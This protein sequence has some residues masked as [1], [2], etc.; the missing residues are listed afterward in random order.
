MNSEFDNLFYD[1]FDLLITNLIFYRISDASPVICY[2]TSFDG[3]EG[4]LCSCLS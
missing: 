1:Y 3:L 2:H 4:D